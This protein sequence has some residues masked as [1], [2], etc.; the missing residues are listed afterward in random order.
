MS[1]SFKGAHFPKDIILQAIRYYVSYKLSFRDIEEIMLE[2]GVAIDHSTI[3]RWVIKYMP[4]LEKAA[5][6]KKVSVSGS[7]RMD[8]T[9][10]KVKGEWKYYYRAID[11]HGHVI[12]S[13]LQDKRN[14]KAAK[15]FFETAITNNG[16][17]SK[18]VIDKS[19]SNLSALRLI[20]ECLVTLSLTTIVIL[21][22]KYLNNLV[23]QS[24][25]KLKAKM[26]QCL[27][28]KSDEGAK[29]TLSGVELW[30]MIK[31]DQLENP[32][33]LPSWSQLYTLAG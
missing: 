15:A 32:K 9:Y 13:L 6:K 14:T 16:V 30:S 19:G 20:N 22:S 27:G 1:I 8:E 33:S 18:V 31:K 21:Q 24:H 23:E 4:L 26:R 25:R 11:K 29:A 28:W 10:V 2:R 7:W 5:L 17:P 12:D 3:S